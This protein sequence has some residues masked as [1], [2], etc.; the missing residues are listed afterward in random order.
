MYMNNNAVLQ[1]TNVC[2]EQDSDDDSDADDW[3]IC[4]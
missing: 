1:N 4:I 2:D 3:P